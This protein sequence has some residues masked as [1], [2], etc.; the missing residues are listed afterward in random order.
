MTKVAAD[1]VE[2]QELV[3][4][5]S[6]GVGKSCLTVRFLKDEFTN[7]YDPTI[8][9]N[10]RKHI[11]VD[12]TNTTVNII[13]T[14]GQHEYTALRDQHLKDGKGF[15]LVFAC[16][17]RATWEEIKQLRDQIDLPPDQIEVDDTLVES[18]C[19]TSKIPYLKTSA[20]ENTNVTES[21][22]MLVRECRRFFPP[23]AGG[24]GAGS[25]HHGGGR[26]GGRGGGAGG[27]GGS[28]G[29]GAKKKTKCVIL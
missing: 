1:P 21:F 10:Y 26:G 14:A 11:T 20:K 22:H 24:D 2:I 25:P 18:F 6:G 16:N 13:D 19:T 7:D 23:G 3:V 12:N 29:G 8:E 17:D 15:L 5:G 9:E 27:G 4:V 28:G